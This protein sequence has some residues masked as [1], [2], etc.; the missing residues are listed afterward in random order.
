V[1]ATLASAWP[2]DVP[3]TRYPVLLE[4]PA[5]GQLPWVEEPERFFGVVNRFLDGQAI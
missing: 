2:N 3:P 1:I 5:V 4:L